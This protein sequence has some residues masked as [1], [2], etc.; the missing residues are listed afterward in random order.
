MTRS[1]TESR[2]SSPRKAVATVGLIALLTLIVASCGVNPQPTGYGDDYRDN[3]ML[4]CTGVD[5]E[6]GES[7]EGYEQLASEKQCTCV[8]D[9]LEEKVP[10][11]EAKEFE[12][13]Q[14]EAESG[15][16]IKVPDNIAAIFDDCETS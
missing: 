2:A 10:F 7:P 4:G 3:F 15:S 5:P 12:D 1:V 9:G 8:Y 16:D 14:A 6:T 13:T 11:E